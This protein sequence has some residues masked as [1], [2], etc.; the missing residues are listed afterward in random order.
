MLVHVSRRGDN[1]DAGAFD[2]AMLRPMIYDRAALAQLLFPAAAFLI[3]R[4]IARPG[5]D[6]V[7]RRHEPTSKRA[8]LALFEDHSR[9]IVRPGVIVIDVIAFDDAPRQPSARLQI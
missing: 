6:Y 2:V 8:I 9:E 4:T 3:D 7:F 5:Q 1:D